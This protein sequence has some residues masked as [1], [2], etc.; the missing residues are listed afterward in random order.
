MAKALRLL[1][2]TLILAIGAPCHADTLIKRV[3]NGNIYSTGENTR[4][5]VFG[6]DNE[7][8]LPFDGGDYAPWDLVYE[9]GVT[10]GNWKWLGK[11]TQGYLVKPSTSTVRVYPVRGDQTKYI[12]IAPI[13][14]QPSIVN[15]VSAKHLELYVD[16]EFSRWSLSMT[17]QGF[18]PN[19]LLKPGY[20]GDGTFQFR[21]E[22]N[23]L[24]LLGSKIMDGPVQVL[25]LHNPFLVD[26]EGINRAV[27]ESLVDGVITLTADLS[28]LT[29]PIL[30]DPT[31]GPDNPEKDTGL[32][33]A[34][35]TTGYGQAISIPLFAY[36][37]GATVA[38]FVMQF[39]L[40]A[41][42]AGSTIDSS[43]LTLYARASLIAPV[44]YTLHRCTRTDWDDNGNATLNASANWT[45]YLDDTP[46]TPW[47]NLGGDY[48]TPSDGSFTISA[49]G[50]K[51][52]DITTLTQDAVTNRGRILSILG[53]CDNENPGSAQQI[54]ISSLENVTAGERPRLTVEYT[55]PVATTINTHLGYPQMVF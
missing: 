9:N 8:A 24:T 40:T 44:V 22:L 51:T 38:R 43:T 13:A 26:A 29:Y 14:A 46:D 4:K 54:S 2:L 16:K 10:V 34:A 39:D 21:F 28:G 20:S 12:E 41:I 55:E 5:A 19:I 52:H 50:D 18:K 30:V 53:K 25:K 15:Q 6:G 42:P 7:N 27:D 33:K 1:I 48:S 36:P 37:G 35:P 3:A 49:L 23:N 47:T 45:N 32:Y 17:P 11:G 31:L